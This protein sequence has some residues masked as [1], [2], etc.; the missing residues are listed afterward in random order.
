MNNKIII[1]IIVIL[2]IGIIIGYF[3]LPVLSQSAGIGQEVFGNS[4]GVSPP[5]LP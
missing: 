3:L 5:S 4:S 1:L 2:V